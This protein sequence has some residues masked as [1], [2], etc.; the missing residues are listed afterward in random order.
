MEERTQ[1]FRSLGLARERCGEGSGALWDTALS[2]SLDPPSS[3]AGPEE[4]ASHL[5]HPLSALRTTAR[6]SVGSHR[7]P[8]VPALPLI[9]NP[10]PTTE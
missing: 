6:L 4:K 7:V 8:C 9:T 5:L 3:L 10:G 1:P 2:L